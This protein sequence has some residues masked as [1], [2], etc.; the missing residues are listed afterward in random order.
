MSHFI[1]WSDF[2]QEYFLRF[3]PAQIAWQTRGIAGDSS[4]APLVLVEGEGPRGGT[5][6]IVYAPDRDGLFA[7]ITAVL[8]RLSLSVQD[9]RVVTSRSGMSLDTFTV[10][11]V[12]GRALHDPAQVGRLQR[13]LTQALE[14]S[15]AD[16]APIRRPPARALRHFPIT[17]RVEFHDDAG[18]TRLALVCAD[19]PGLLAGV[20]QVFLASGIRVH[21]ARIATFGERVE[22][23]FLITDKSN[24]ALASPARQALG[25]ALVRRVDETVAGPLEGRYVIA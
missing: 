12:Q 19:R 5:E 21:D 16:I 23:F 8:D 25:E 24:R 13:A 22:D 14:Q 17:T 6:V 10:L 15:P 7:A 1:I 20:A 11:D 4:A 18:G 9:A 2:P 3:T